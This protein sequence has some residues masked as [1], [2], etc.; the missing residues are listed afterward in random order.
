M[1][2][3]KH[4]KIYELV[5]KHIY[6]ARGEK[7]WELLD[8]K[9]LM[10]IDTLREL[11]GCPITINN[12]NWGGDRNWSG[13]R[14]GGFY[15]SLGEYDKSLSQH[16]YGRAVDMLIKGM[17]AEKVRQFIYKNKDKFPYI[18]FVETKI[19]WVHIDVR[20]CRAITCWAPDGTTEMK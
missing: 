5:P 8:E 16:K 11:L 17:E 13:V 18:T 15:A 20:N 2:K 7:A 1:Y 4:F 10:T 6:E 14:T 12:Y 3:C 9:L 19:N